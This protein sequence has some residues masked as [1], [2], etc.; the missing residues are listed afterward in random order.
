[1]NTSSTFFG[2]WWPILL[3]PTKKQPDVALGNFFTAGVVA[4]GLLLSELPAF[5][6]AV[7]R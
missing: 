2:A 3:F 1:V 5:E 4:L 6:N 7:P